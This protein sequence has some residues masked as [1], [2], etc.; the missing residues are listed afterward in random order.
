LAAAK[1]RGVQLGRPATINGRA[2]EVSKLK[3]QG[4]GLR[5]IARELKM[6]PSSVHKAL[7]L[8]S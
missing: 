3:A 6:P 2:A 4:L 1:A 5:A 7:Q 8:A